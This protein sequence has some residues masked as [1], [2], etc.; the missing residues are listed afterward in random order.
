MEHQA[1]PQSTDATN[2]GTRAW[3]PPTYRVHSIAPQAG[4]TVGDTE[5]VVRGFADYRPS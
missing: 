4:N 1:A 2:A 3:A 5:N